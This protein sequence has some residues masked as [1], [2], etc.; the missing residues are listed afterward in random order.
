[1]TPERKGRSTI[2]T[3]KWTRE[4][5]IE[6]AQRFETKT[7]WMQGCRG[8]YQKAAREDW[9]DDPNVSGHMKKRRKSYEEKVRMTAHSVLNPQADFLETLN[10]S[11]EF[12]RGLIHAS[13]EY[14]EWLKTKG[15]GETTTP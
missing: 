1:M 2:R 12:V 4:K 3:A 7:D 15:V 13:S 11:S 8:S 14:Q 6:S 9:L 10:N 5:V